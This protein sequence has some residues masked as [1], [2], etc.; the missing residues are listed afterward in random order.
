MLGTNN[1]NRER[2][3]LACSEGGENNLKFI[4]E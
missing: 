3:L 4:A 1:P 2:S